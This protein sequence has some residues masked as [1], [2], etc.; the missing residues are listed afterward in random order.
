MREM[1]AQSMAK[2]DK[3]RELK[4]HSELGRESEAR[5]GTTV[6]SLRNQVYKC[7]LVL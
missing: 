3:I 5:F 2:D 1:Q 4:A 6:N 7:K